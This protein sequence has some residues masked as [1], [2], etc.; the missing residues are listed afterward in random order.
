MVL[1]IGPDPRV[2]PNV[3]EKNPVRE[4]NRAVTNPTRSASPRKTDR[5]TWYWHSPW[6]LPSFNCRRR[7]T[8][9][10]VLC[11]LPVLLSSCRRLR[12]FLHGKL[13]GMFVNMWWSVLLLLVWFNLVVAG[14]VERWE[15]CLFF[16]FVAKISAFFI[17]LFGWY[18]WFVSSK[19]V[20]FIAF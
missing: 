15:I 20:F 4:T 2:R 9:A 11:R 6:P 10:V 18:H 8:T 12:Q 13:W 1:K 5:K 17:L 3:S 14:F 16:F 7:L 19:Y